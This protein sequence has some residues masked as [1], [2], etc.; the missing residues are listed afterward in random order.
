MTC[1]KKLPKLCSATLNCLLFADSFC[2][3]QIKRKTGF[4]KLQDHFLGGDSAVS[5]KG[6]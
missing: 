2:F 5:S 1:T 6:Y 4:A 3:D